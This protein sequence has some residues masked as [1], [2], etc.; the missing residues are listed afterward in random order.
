ML[1]TP[2]GYN[3]DG[4]ELRP[5]EPSN[6]FDSHNNSFML[7][8][9]AIR[10]NST[11]FEIANLIKTCHFLTSDNFDQHF[12]DLQQWELINSAVVTHRSD[13]LKMLLEKGISPNIKGLKSRWHGEMSLLQNVIQESSGESSPEML[14]LL[15]NYNVNINNISEHGHS[16]KF[17]SHC[18]S[19]MCCVFQYD[20]PDMMKLLIEDYDITYNWNGTCTLYMACKLGAYKC[21][22]VLFEDTKYREHVNLSEISLYE[23]MY[24]KA[25]LLPVLY[26]AGVQEGVFTPDD[27]G[28]CIWE[29]VR[30]MC[31]YGDDLADDIEILLNF[32][33]P[34]NYT[35]GLLSTTSATSKVTINILELLLEN[36]CSKVYGHQLDSFAGAVYLLFLHG[37][38]AKSS[39][40]NEYLLYFFYNVL[41]NHQDEFTLSSNEAKTLFLCTMHTTY[42]KKFSKQIEGPSTT[43]KQTPNLAILSDSNGNIPSTLLEPSDQP[44]CF[45]LKQAIRLAI[46]NIDFKEWSLE[47]I[48]KDVLA[49]HAK[50]CSCLSYAIR[51]WLPVWP[52]KEYQEFIKKVLN[53]IKEEPGTQSNALDQ[54]KP[55]CRS[56][57]ELTR[58]V[59]FNSLCLPRTVAIESLIVPNTLKQY[60]CL[61]DEA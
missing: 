24:N 50:E 34:T 61:A 54:Y 28:F 15:C 52:H 14:R 37:A 36:T 25:N 48:L 60:L 9:T 35:A 47:E 11:M 1:P 7:L 20:N 6:E 55:H 29:L 16:F 40:V 26:E 43:R 22:Q 57:K 49:N 17:I 12:S 33:S 46:L 27:L 23:V 38:M 18:K 45:P 30:N 44:Q 2:K 56:L 41:R 21:A 13:I 42:S 53:E 3:L 8:K 4:C 10:Q 19:A 31:R 39:V 5:D 58:I 32:G 59:I 51:T